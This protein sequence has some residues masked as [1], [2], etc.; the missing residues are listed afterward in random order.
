MNIDQFK[1]QLGTNV[2]LR[3]LPV[4]F[5]SYGEKLSQKDDD[6]RVEEINKN[7]NRIKLHNIRTGHILELQCDNIREYR[8]PHFVM[9][10]CKI[11]INGNTINIEP[12][13]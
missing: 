12:I 6:W 9:L 13:V 4:W 10:K 7:P 8:S 1:K 11:I 3:P 5:G 2:K